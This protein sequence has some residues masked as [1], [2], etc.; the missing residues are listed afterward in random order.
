MC[1][2]IEDMFRDMG[3]GKMAKF[4]LDKLNA[5]KDGCMN[6]MVFLALVKELWAASLEKTA[7]LAFAA[8]I[9]KVT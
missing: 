4:S 7:E 2:E 8:L 9:K 3:A 1:A 6:R 5:R